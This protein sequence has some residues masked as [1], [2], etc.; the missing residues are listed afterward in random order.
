M[1]GGGWW[2]VGGGWWSWWWLVGGG[3]WVVVVVMVVGGGW[4]VALSPR[5]GGMREAIR[6]PSGWRV[7]LSSRIRE[8]FL[9]SFSIFLLKLSGFLND[10]FLD[11]RMILNPSYILPVAIRITPALPQSFFFVFVLSS[12]P[13]V[14][15][16]LFRHVCFSVWQMLAS[17]RGPKSTQTR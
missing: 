5:P 16:P 14:F 17:R 7:R 2:A 9:E 11:S 10:S 12:L 6:R 3:W 13:S 1:V 8:S 4:W 15:W